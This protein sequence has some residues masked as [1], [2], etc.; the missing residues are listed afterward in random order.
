MDCRTCKYR[1]GDMEY[2]YCDIEVTNNVFMLDSNHA[3]C[4]YHEEEE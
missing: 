4:P 2:F 3:E 1:K